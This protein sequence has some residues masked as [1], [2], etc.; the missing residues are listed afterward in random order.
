M[1]NW[2]P[3][4]DGRCGEVQDA[5]ERHEHEK[6][7]SISFSPEAARADIC[8]PDWPSRKNCLPIALACGSPSSAPASRWNAG[9]LRPRGSTTCRCPAGRCRDGRARRFPS[10]WKMW[11][12]ILPPAVCWMKRTS[13]ALSVWADTPACPWAGPPHAAA[14]RWSCWNRTS[15]REKPIAGYRAL[16]A[17]SARVSSRPSSRSAAAAP[18]AGP[19]TRSAASRRTDPAVVRCRCRSISPPGRARRQWRGPIA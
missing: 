3:A 15:C 17:W 8:S 14:C 7:S 2:W 4:R 6:H 19:A 13:P 9:T 16:P 11:P 12:V 10:S 5:K 1:W 18:S